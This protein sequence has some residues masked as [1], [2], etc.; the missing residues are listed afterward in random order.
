LAGAEILGEALKRAGRD[1]TRDKLIEEL[2]TLH[3]FATG[4][5]PPVTYTPTRR[6]GARGA[7]VLKLDLTGQTLGAGEWVEAE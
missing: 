6:L 1:L 7:Y 5:A 2:E 4:Y 3:G